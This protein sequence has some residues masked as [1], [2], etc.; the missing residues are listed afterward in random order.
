MYQGS[1]FGIAAASFDDEFHG[2]DRHWLDDASWVDFC[3]GWL[4]G[5]DQVLDDLVATIE[6]Q[7]RRVPMYERI[8]DEP[9]LTSWWQAS[10]GEPEALPV[11][12]EIRRSLST[13]YARDFDSI[14]F[15]FYRDGNDSV[16]W[17]GDRH[18]HDVPNPIVAIVGVGEPRPFR[19]RP[20]GGGHSISYPSGH[21]DLLVMGG[22]CQH[23]WQHSVPKLSGDIGPRISISY[24]HGA[25]RIGR[26]RSGGTATWG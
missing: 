13:R 1:L 23:R 3:P 5:A 16:A 25:D 11:L 15:N 17:H 21:G 6:W 18:R 22:A 4:S 12:G 26:L 7:H 8:V 19:L 14:G 9:R 2:L 10:S 20:A 24:R